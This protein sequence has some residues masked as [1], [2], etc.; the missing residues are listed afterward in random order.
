MDFVCTCRQVNYISV[1]EFAGEIASE[2]AL[3]KAPLYLNHIQFS[4]CHSGFENYAGYGTRHGSITVK[5]FA[6]TTIYSLI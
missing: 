2:A 5:T 6:T 1:A 3:M 4:S